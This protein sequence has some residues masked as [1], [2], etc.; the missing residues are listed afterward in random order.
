MTAAST[1]IPPVGTVSGA[2]VADV[3]VPKFVPFVPSGVVWSTLLNETAPAWVPPAPLIVIATLFAPVA[4]FTRPH[5]SVAKAVP[6]ARLI[7]VI[8]TPA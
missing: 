7:S 6:T 5:S 1:S 2:L 3:P 8:A 4:G